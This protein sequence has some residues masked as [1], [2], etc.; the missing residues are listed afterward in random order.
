MPLCLYLLWL[1]RMIC[2]IENGNENEIYLSII[3]IQED[4]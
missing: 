3:N 1:A 4:N 2:I